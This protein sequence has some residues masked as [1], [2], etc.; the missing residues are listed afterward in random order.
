MLD[1]LLSWNL[2]KPNGVLIWDD[3][4]W[5]RREYGNKVPKLAIDQFLSGHVGSYG[6]LWAFKQ[7][8]IRKKF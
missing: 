8:A 1:S 3:Y 2:L 5:K 6:P 7:V 4:L